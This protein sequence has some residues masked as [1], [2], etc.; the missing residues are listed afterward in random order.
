MEDL[1]RLVDKMQDDLLA[2]AMMLE[3]IANVYK[4]AHADVNSI[5]QNNSP[6]QF[7]IHKE[8]Q[9]GR[10]TGYQP[11]QSIPAKEGLVGTPGYAYAFTGVEPIT[12][13]QYE[14]ESEKETPKRKY[15]MASKPARKAAKKP[16]KKEMLISHNFNEGEI[17]DHIKYPVS[18]GPT[19]AAT[20]REI[21]DK[22]YKAEQEFEFSNLVKEVRKIVP[23]ATYNNV[24]NA[25][26]IYL[27]KEGLEQM[28]RYES[29]VRQLKLV[30]VPTTNEPDTKEEK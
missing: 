27:R 17:P 2:K 16:I 25:Y 7:E 6:I 14:K 9:V 29:G 5:I 12:K 30:K 3:E 10:T 1:T 15:T 4:K 22:Y 8:V 23:T 18:G 20:T 13:E 28:S 19:V 24:D 21:V 11:P 26:R